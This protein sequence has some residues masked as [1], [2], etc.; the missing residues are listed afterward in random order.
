[1]AGNFGSMLDYEDDWAGRYRVQDADLVGVSV[2]PSIAYRVSDKL[3]LGAAVNAMY[4]M[5]DQRV[6]INNAL[7]SLGDGRLEIDDD[8]WGWGG[9]VGVLYE[10]TP[11]TR[12]GLTY[13]SQI[14]LDFSGPAQ[15]SGIGPI[16]TRCCSRAAC[17][18]RAW[19]S[20]PRCRSR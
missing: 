18:M 3:S 15:F 10:P 14:D 16:L 1:M 17:S 12:L 19:M 8:T 9:N 7:P 13:T 4:G 11:G 2:V 6:A 5:F 20:A